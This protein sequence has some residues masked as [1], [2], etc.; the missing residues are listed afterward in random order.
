VSRILKTHMMLASI[1]EARSTPPMYRVFNGEHELDCD[2]TETQ[3]TAAP[4]Q[5]SV[6][7][8]T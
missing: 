3:Q 4:H 2:D 8:D 1:D 6:D 5:R 7:I